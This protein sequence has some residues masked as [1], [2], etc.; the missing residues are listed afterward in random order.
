MGA[1]DC[2]LLGEA[3][4]VPNLSGCV[5]SSSHTSVRRGLK[6]ILVSSQAVSAEEQ[7]K[8]EQLLVQNYGVRERKW[9]GLWFSSP[10]KVR[11]RQASCSEG[12]LI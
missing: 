7:Q 11:R 5:P 8:G 12:E 9:A 2:P 3:Q 10:R 1:R 6:G 4:L